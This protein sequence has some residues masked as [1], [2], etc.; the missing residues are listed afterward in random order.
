M[1]AVQWE[2]GVAGRTSA[3]GSNF[4]NGFVDIHHHGDDEIFVREVFSRA[5]GF[6]WGRN[7]RVRNLPA[8]LVTDHQMQVA[9]VDPRP[10]DLS[11]G[12]ELR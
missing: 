3:G 2:K 7:L 5:Y 9:R 10:L 4:G 11:S 1:V 8:L 6:V 12:S